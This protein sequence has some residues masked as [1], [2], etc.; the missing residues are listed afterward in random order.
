MKS[1]FATVA[2]ATATRAILREDKYPTHT[3]SI[4]LD[5]SHEEHTTGAD[6]SFK[7]PFEQLGPE[8]QSIYYKGS[9]TFSTKLHRMRAPTKLHDKQGQRVMGQ[10]VTQKKSQSLLQTIESWFRPSGVG[11]RYTIADMNNVYNL[12][13]LGE[14]HIGTP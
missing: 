13:Y 3:S 5:I 4:T 2:L 8:V 12:N 6:G 7:H 10:Q 11:E 9:K 1:L 14:I